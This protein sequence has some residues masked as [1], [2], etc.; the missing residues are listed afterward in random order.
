MISDID[1]YM[2]SL[3]FTTES[4]VFQYKHLNATHFLSDII[5]LGKNLENYY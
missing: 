5:L 2:C 4:L 3:N 1:N